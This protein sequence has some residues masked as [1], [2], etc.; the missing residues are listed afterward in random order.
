MTTL[1]APGM[2]DDFYSRPACWGSNNIL[3]V[4]SRNSVNCR[5][6][7]NAE[8]SYVC[9]L[10]EDSERYAQLEWVPDSSFLSMGVSQGEVRVMDMHRRLPSLDFIPERFTDDVVGAMNWRNANELVVGYTSGKLRRYDKRVNEFPTCNPISAHR[11]RV[12][13]IRWNID[14]TLFATG[15]GDGMVLC[16]DVRNERKPLARVDQ[17]SSSSSNTTTSTVKEPTRKWRGRKHRS[18]VKTLAWC[19]WQPDLLATGGGTLD[20]TI[21][22]WSASTG[23][24]KKKVIFTDSQ[25]S[26]LHWSQSCKEIVSTHGYG[27]QRS[28]AAAPRKHSVLVHNYPKGELVGRIFDIG[29]GRISDS[30]LSPDGT[31]IV[32]CGADETLRVYNIFGTLKQPETDDDPLTRYPIR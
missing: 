16:W 28:G 6:M 18:T 23:T 8:V 30:C 32:S 25:V 10:Y 19:P 22:F 11:A 20:G 21:R 1:S 31:Q 14:G 29:H 4:A 24:P 9:P 17:A 26:S 2:A 3:A 27:F 15:A 5:N 13:G 7:E 12:C